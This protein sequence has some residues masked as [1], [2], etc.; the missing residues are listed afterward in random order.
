MLL[1]TNHDTE[2]EMEAFYC[3]LKY[4]LLFQTVL[5]KKKTFSVIYMMLYMIWPGVECCLSNYLIPT[6]DFCH[7]SKKLFCVCSKSIPLT[8][9]V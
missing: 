2:A 8:S 1:V 4:H 7:K 9:S 6:I 5:Y 3:N